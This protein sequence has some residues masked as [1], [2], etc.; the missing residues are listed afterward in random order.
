MT[1]SVPR[2]YDGSNPIS[3]LQRCLVMHQRPEAL[4]L[5]PLDLVLTVPPIPGA[6]F[7]DFDHHSEVLDAAYQW[8]RR[9]IAEL[10]DE[11]DPALAAIMATKD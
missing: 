10:A 6:N 11:G 2:A 5:G 9:R 8:C 3:V 4:P 1:Q 7:M